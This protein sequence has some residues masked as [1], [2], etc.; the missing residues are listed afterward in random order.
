MSV[1]LF[2][3]LRNKDNARRHPILSALLYVFCPQA[4]YWWLAG[5]EPELPFDPVW[6]VLRDMGDGKTLVEQL[7]AYELGDFR[8]EI[9]TYV[10]EV[11]TFRR[12]HA[13]IKA[14]ERLPFFRGGQLPLSR[15][16]GA[17]DGIR[18]LDGDWDNLF[19]YARAWAFL[20]PDWMENMR[21]SQS[22][23]VRFKIETLALTL[24]GI[25]LP[26][27]WDVPVWQIQI[28]HVREIRI[29]ALLQDDQPDFLRLA[30]LA[31]SSPKG[32]RPWQ[33]RPQVFT[34]NTET[35]EA[36]AADIPLA[37]RRL[38]QVVKHLAE[39]AQQEVYAPLNALRNP[40]LCQACGYVQLCY[41]RKMLSSRLFPS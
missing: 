19:A 32:N 6:Q 14:P 31:L 24:N 35:G 36:N 8:D 33:T 40:S 28:E 17:A 20:Y 21:I 16:F 25:R 7:E 27:S 29:G 4:A 39:A 15:R 12:H 10:G 37:D 2:L 22:A 9:K 30:L 5:A 23:D 3:A 26:I 11:E 41:Q 18:H 34:L 1:D 38:P 13:H